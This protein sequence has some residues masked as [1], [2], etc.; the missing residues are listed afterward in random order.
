MPEKD[1]RPAE[2]TSKFTNFVKKPYEVVVCCSAKDNYNVQFTHKVLEIVR[3]SQHYP[4]VMRVV[5]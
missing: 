1:L 4:H 3:G 2:N 5:N